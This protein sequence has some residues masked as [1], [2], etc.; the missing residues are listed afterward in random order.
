[1]RADELRSLSLFDGLTDDQL[2]ELIEGSTE[3]SRRARSRSV[4]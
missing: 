3:A 2:G 1:M 4:L